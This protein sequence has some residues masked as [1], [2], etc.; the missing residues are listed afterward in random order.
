MTNVFTPDTWK[1]LK[2]LG[3]GSIAG[4]VI[5]GY[6]LLRQDYQELKSDNKVTRDQMYELQNS[7]IKDNTKAMIEMRMKM[8][9]LGH[10]KSPHF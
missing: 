8:E 1:M 7:V 4:I 5:F 10:E 2:D 6:Y 3:K 9:N